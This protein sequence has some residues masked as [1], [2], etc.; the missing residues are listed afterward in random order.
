MTILMFD[1]KNNLSAAATSAY[2]KG[3]LA[4][5]LYADDTLIVGAASAHV[6]EYMKAIELKYEEYMYE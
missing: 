5:V 3:D 2:D 4:D 1:A 6:G